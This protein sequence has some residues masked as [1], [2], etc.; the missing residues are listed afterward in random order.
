MNQLFC[1]F[2]YDLKNCKMRIICLLIGLVLTTLSCKSIK[3]ID[4]PIIFDDER[5]Q[6]SLEYLEK[7]Y[8]IVQETPEIDPKM[9]VVHWTAIPSLEKSYE[10]FE[11]SKLPNWRPE[12]TAASALNVSSQFLIDQNGR[13]YR[14]MPE[15]TMARHVIGLNHCAI[16]IENVG[17]TA[18]L[19]LTKKQLKANI[20]LIEYLK[21]KYPE[22]DYV[23]GHMEYRLFENH[24]LWKEV[25]EGYR[26]QKTDPGQDFIDQ[27]RR[28]TSSM[29]WAPVPHK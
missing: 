16:G 23:I 27:I 20:K 21:E 2:S 12:I 5:K 8:G 1:L 10:A 4:K 14:L 18:D 6:L 15:T 29:N 19:P 13:I 22:I 28:S 11:N 3:I 9:I 25:D 17:G 26:T 24:P 7:R